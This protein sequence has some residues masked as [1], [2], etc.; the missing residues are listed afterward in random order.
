MPR[1]KVKPTA[2][3][4]S[5]RGDQ[6]NWVAFDKDTSAL[7]EA[8]YQKGSKKVRVDKERF[9][10]LSLSHDEVLSNFTVI[11]RKIFSE[12][13]PQSLDDED[14]VIG[15][16]RRYDDEMKRRAVK[17]VVPEFFGKD[18]FML[19]AKKKAQ[20]NE[21]TD[22]VE[23]YGG[24]VSKKFTNKVIPSLLWPEHLAVDCSHLR[25]GRGSRFCRR[26]EAG[27]RGQS[28]RA[29]LGLHCRQHQRGKA[30]RSRG[31]CH[32]ECLTESM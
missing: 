21:G 13:L 28:T 18:T 31:L 3:Q 20:V 29:V 30:C 23:L 1:K 25:R 14:D 27:C 6:N 9:V 12:H 2:V 15:I 7:L 5:W 17:R 26:Y 4:W 22:E 19:L 32:R 16:Q 10:D 11:Q 24:V 8:E